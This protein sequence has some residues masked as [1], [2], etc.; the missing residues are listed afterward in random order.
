[1]L[2]YKSTPC[3][4]GTNN[5]ILKPPVHY[6]GDTNSYFINQLPT[7]EVQIVAFQINP[8][9]GGTLLRWRYNPTLVILTPLTLTRLF[10]LKSNMIG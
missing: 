4:G 8:D 1:M 6:T 3:A 7:L 9:A 5:C 2:L 10:C